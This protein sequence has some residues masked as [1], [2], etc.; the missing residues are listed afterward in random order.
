MDVTV[1][2]T[3]GPLFSRGKNPRYE[4]DKRLGGLLSLSER[5]REGKNILPRW[6]STSDNP[7]LN[8]TDIFRHKPL[9]VYT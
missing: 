4:F 2:F 3:L 8:I 1:C 6:K 9:F 7:L 5:F